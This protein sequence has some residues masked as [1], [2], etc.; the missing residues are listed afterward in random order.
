M[1]SSRPAGTSPKYGILTVSH[2]AQD[3]KRKPTA[4]SI[5]GETW[6]YRYSSVDFYNGR[7]RGYSNIS[8]NLRVKLAP[9]TDSSA[10]RQIDYFT[11]GSTQEE[12]LAVQGTPSG[13]IGSTWHCAYSS[14]DFVNGKVKGYS[15]ISRN[16]RVKLL[17]K[18]ETFLQSP[19]YFTI[20]STQ[21]EVLAVQG[22]PTG[23]IGSTWRYGYSSIDFHNGEVK[24]YSDISKNLKVKLQ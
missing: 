7:V 21:D 17:P 3:C 1:K 8:N 16:L 5:I 11:L 19:G 24:G 10:Q 20:G 4:S 12:V 13:I 14:I 9:K 23:I 2:A 18:V 6:H 15:N 22:T